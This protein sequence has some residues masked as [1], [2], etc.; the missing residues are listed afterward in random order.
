MAGVL[1][2]SHLSYHND[3]EANNEIWNV[4][5]ELE[6]WREVLLPLAS[7]LRWDEPYHPVII[8]GTTSFL[9]SFVWYTEMSTLTS[10][11]LACILVGVFDFIIPL[12]GPIITG[13]NIWTVEMES[14]FVDICEIIACFLQDIIETWQGLKALRHENAKLFF[15]IVIGILGVAAWI[16]STVSNF[17]LTY[18][19]VTGVLLW[20]GLCHQGL[21]HKYTELVWTTFNNL[22]I[23][24]VDKPKFS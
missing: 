15:F 10:V 11:S 12:M 4:K 6:G 1:R 13:T 2:R 20:P 24:L 21:V 16:G 5:H 9:F 17:F 23:N 8:A 14:E 22:K 3:D 7:V 19:I 18:L